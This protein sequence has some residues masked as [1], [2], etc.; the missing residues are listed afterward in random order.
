[1][2]VSVNQL[3]TT[4]NF[5]TRLTAK[6]LTF[7][8]R[9]VRVLFCVSFSFLLFFFYHSVLK[10]YTHCSLLYNYVI[11][12]VFVVVSG[13]LKLLLTIANS[14]RIES[15][16]KNTLI[17]WVN[18]VNNILT[19][20]FFFAYY[21]LADSNNQGLSCSENGIHSYLPYIGLLYIFFQFYLPFC[22]LAITGNE[23]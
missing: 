13:T 23:K 4:V 8:Q 9:E 22:C 7:S 20:F 17:W 19:V 21:L 14:F 6:L 2:M 3:K 10:K 18:F 11:Y 16:A 5:S 15:I 1:M 12:Y